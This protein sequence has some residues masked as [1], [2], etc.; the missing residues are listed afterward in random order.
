MLKLKEGIPCLTLYLSSW[1]VCLG[2]KRLIQNYQKSNGL[3]R[4]EAGG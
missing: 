4:K 2:F 1:D 3:R